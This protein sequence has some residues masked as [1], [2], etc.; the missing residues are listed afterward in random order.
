M[1]HATAHAFKI[2]IGDRLSVTGLRHPSTSRGVL[3][4]DEIIEVAH[5]YGVL[6]EWVIAT[7]VCA[8]IPGET[9]LFDIGETLSS[10]LAN[11]RLVVH[12]LSLDDDYEFTCSCGTQARVDFLTLPGGWFP[13]VGVCNGIIWLTDDLFPEFGCYAHLPAQRPIDTHS[14]DVALIWDTYLE[15]L[16]TKG[17][18]T[19]YQLTPKVRNLIKTRIK[20]FGVERVSIAVANW[21]LSTWHLE[22]GVYEIE[23]VL[24]EKNVQRFCD[25]AEQRK[26]PVDSNGGVTW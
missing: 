16:R 1:E 11:S 13:Q 19:R 26:Q 6:P 7:Y 25:L 5:F 15:S 17:I 20:T 10:R 4:H 24:K 18:R 14:D 3:T 8:I 12:R 9:V 23:T 21:H 22:N 2:A